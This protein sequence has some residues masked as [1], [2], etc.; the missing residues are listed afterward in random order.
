MGVDGGQQVLGLAQGKVVLRDSDDRWADLFRDEAAR[1][2]AAIGPLVTAIEH[3]GSTSIPGIKAKPILDILVGLRRFED[4]RRLVEPLTALGYDYVGT[5]MVPNDH[6]FGLGHP[7]LHLLHAVEHGGYHWTRDLQFRD[8]LRA[9][10]SLAAEYEALKVELA[11]QFPDSRA[12][13]LRGK[14]AFID[15]IADSE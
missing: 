11:A 12:D 13:Y 4:G 6:L 7:R 15:R 5:E 10:P 3:F 8:R 1:L 14:Q 9:E 2:E